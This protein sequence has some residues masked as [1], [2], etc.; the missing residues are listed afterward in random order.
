MRQQRIFFLAKFYKKDLLWGWWLRS[1]EDQYIEQ[2]EGEY[3]EFR[4]GDR[5]LY[6][7]IFGTLIDKRDSGAHY[8]ISPAL[9]IG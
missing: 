5:K 8:R 3:I 7:T 9:R 6:V 4:K 2:L 1:T